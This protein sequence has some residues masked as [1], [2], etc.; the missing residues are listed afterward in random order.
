MSKQLSATRL[1][2]VN[3]HTGVVQTTTSVGQFTG[4]S[5]ALT[6]AQK[7]QQDKARELASAM[8]GLSG[9]YGIGFKQAKAAA[10]AAGINADA[11][12]GSAQAADKARAKFAA[13]VLTNEHALPKQQEENALMRAFGSAANGSA[14]QISSLDTS[15]RLLVGDFVS[16]QEAMLNAKSAIQQFGSAARQ[17]GADTVQTRQQFFGAVDS[18]HQYADTLLKAH[19]PAAKFYADVQ[20]QITALQNAGPLTRSERTA[21]QGLQQWMD[22]AAGSQQG[23]TGRQQDWI[24]LTN[25]SFLPVLSSLGANTKNVR[26]DMSNLADSIAKTG[27]K[28]ESTKA[29]RAQLIED[30]SHTQLGAKG[31]RT[32]VNELTTSLGKVPKSVKTKI[33]VTGTGSYHLTETQKII[34]SLGGNKPVPGLAAG[35]RIR[36]GTTPTADDVLIRASKDETVVSA[37]HSRILAP[38]FAAVGVPG[39]AAGGIVGSY[40][41]TAPGL[42]K[43]AQQEVDD[44]V[45]VI[46]KSVAGATAA[47][48]K[49]ALK[50][51]QSIAGAT[52]TA[53]GDLPANYRAIA[54]FLTGHGYSHTGASGI[55]GN[56]LQESGGNP[57]SAGSG[58]NGLIG[59]TPARAGFVTGN[60]GRDLAV[61]LNAILAYNNAQGGIS[62]L[63]AQPTAASA[64]AYY[65]SHFE[66]PAVATENAERR[67][68][69][70]N[71]V[72]KAMG[73]ASGTTGAKPGWAKVG[74]NGQELVHFHGGETVLPASLTSRVLSTGVVMPG[75]A[76]G[77][78]GK[79]PVVSPPK[80]PGPVSPYPPS[81][82]GKR[83]KDEAELKKLQNQLAALEKTATAHLKKLRLPIDREQLYLLQHPGISDA[84]KK[85]LEAQISRQESAVSKY[86]KKA[87]AGEDKLDKEITLLK[88]IIAGDPKGK[89]P[90][91]GKLPPGIGKLN[92]KQDLALLAKDVAALAALKK[93]ATAK[94]KTLNRPVQEDELYLLTHPGLGAGK[95]AAIE[96]ALKKAQAAVRTYRKKVT[97]Q[98]DTYTKT[99]SLLRSLTGNPKDPKYGGAG[100]TDSGS[101]SGD[102]GSGSGGTSD[103]GPPP[104]QFVG[105]L[106]LAPSSGGA[107]ITGG[108][109]GG[110]GGTGSATL[111]LPGLAVP[112]VTAGP[113]MSQFQA[114]AAAA[115]SQSGSQ[116]TA[117]A[118]VQHLATL[119]QLART[120]PAA[121]GGHLGT[122]LNSRSRSALSSARWSAS[123][124]PFA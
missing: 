57:E 29:D 21:L 44:S 11:W 102:D 112:A 64:A 98:E 23:L 71:A 31:A 15:F 19:T 80:L 55:A 5:D 12:T 116:A 103:S 7:R 48:I 121:T 53:I 10:I 9:Q 50:A 70:A 115:A 26:T 96:A 93:T 13:Y 49:A 40:A 52:T 36:A 20:R 45:T 117:D 75:Y 94:L 90:P 3:L 34:G 88:K 72:F 68:A 14:S 24:K 76:D 6:A 95:K 4:Q 83:A 119:V 46:E 104:G 61:Q 74:E 39:Y 81:G 92:Q 97:G 87:T 56:I 22:K 89:P 65:M 18:I 27:T 33:S 67:E 111:G 122:E 118:I 85:Q 16:K 114:Y 78:I 42:G 17:T 59:W 77:T 113:A 99:I 66:R 107:D 63:N 35:G 8:E 60:P 106:P 105:T 51:V 109:S 41:G 38:S 32:F 47:A 110:L 124:A 2:L 37:A 108:G 1:P 100:S 84:R 86:R 123:P 82:G 30:L 58:G 73:Y 62:T 43:W 69:G 54:T 25:S 120:N 79:K 28:S 101:G 91:L